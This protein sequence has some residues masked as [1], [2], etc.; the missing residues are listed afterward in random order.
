MTVS[1]QTITIDKS[2]PSDAMT[3]KN[4]KKGSEKEEKIDLRKLI[5]VS[6]LLG[7]E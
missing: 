2:V 6:T 1:F 4:D 3:K 5:P 7:G